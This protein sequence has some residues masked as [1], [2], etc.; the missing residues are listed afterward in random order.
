MLLIANELCPSYVL[1]LFLFY[2]IWALHP[3]YCEDSN[4]SWS[5]NTQIQQHRRTQCRKGQ[6]LDTA[7]HKKYCYV[8]FL[9]SWLCSRLKFHL[10]DPEEDFWL[11]MFGLLFFLSL[12]MPVFHTSVIRLDR[13]LGNIFVW[14]KTSTSLSRK[15]LHSLFHL[16]IRTF[17]KVH[18]ICLHLA[19]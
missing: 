5:R 7:N 16:R 2:C 19:S 4:T 1:K 12:L 8:I 10:T 3:L 13:V 11:V 9:L 15:L 18:C 14:N 17:P 6:A